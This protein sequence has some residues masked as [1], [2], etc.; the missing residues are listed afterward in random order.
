MQMDIFKKPLMATNNNYVKIFSMKI[1][2]CKEIN[3]TN[4]LIVIALI[5]LKSSTNFLY[6]CP[7]IQVNF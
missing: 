5:G 1:N 2:I 7:P 6:N 3:S 4:E